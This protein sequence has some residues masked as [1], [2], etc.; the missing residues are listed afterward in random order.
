MR[1]LPLA[2]LLA[3]GSRIVL[4]DTIE[5]PR[6][7]WRYV[8]VAAKEPNAVVNCQFEVLS[9]NAE[10]RVVWMARK[11]LEFFRAGDREHILASSSFGSDGKL[12]SLAPA[13]GDYAVVVENG[14]TGRLPAKVK[15]KVWLESPVSP[16][17]ASP[18]RRMAVILISCVVFFGI[19]SFSAY[20]LSR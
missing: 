11:D 10:V 9:G 8:E 13:A 5:V 17:Y 18:Q 12:R 20:R 3:A 15:L 14:P 19:V 4:D 1:L 16:R 7:E 2:L 6:G